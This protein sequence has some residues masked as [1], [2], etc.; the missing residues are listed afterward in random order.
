MLVTLD[1]YVTIE[2]PSDSV[3]DYCENHLTLDNPEYI[4]A[5]KRNSYKARFLDKKLYLYKIENDKFILPFGTFKDIVK[6]KVPNTIYRNEIKAL[7]SKKIKSGIKLYDYQQKAL[8]A[9][10]KAKNGIL[11]GGCGSGKTQI[12][13][14]LIA[15]LG[16]RA[17]WL[18]H[19]GDLLS[20]SYNRAKNSLECSLGKITEGK[21]NIQDVTFATVQTMVKL[22]LE[23]YKRKFDVI[24]VDECHHAVGSP[25][26]MKMFYK[27]ISSLSARYKY[28]LTATPDRA[29][30]LTK[31]M[32]ALLGNKEYE[33]SRKSIG[34][35]IVDAQ[36]KPIMWEEEPKGV[37]KGRDLLTQ[38]PIY[39][40]DYI[41]TDGTYIYSKLINTL[42]TWDER[43]DLI[44]KIVKDNPDRHI[45]ILCNLV[46]H[47]K[48]LAEDLKAELLI[49][50]KSA[51][52]R[53]EAK[54]RLRTGKSKVSVATVALLKEGVDIPILDTLIFA[55]PQKNKTIIVQSIGRIER[56]Y[57]GKLN[58]IVYDI[59]DTKIPYCMGSYSK[60]KRIIKRRIK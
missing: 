37:Y 36:Y 38:E 20:Q 22:D 6:L 30:G 45:L 35:K 15:E 2:N 39:E 42:S 48:L 29:D 23:E 43:N 1:N 57:P 9:L 26:K 47:A 28:G 5:L 21:V 16:G 4:N 32:Y 44:K 51:K 12:G 25:T 58:P 19:T 49:G 10:K 55:T 53:E 46:S 56:A 59:V 41:D 33:I 24:I 50:S 60:R 11:V 7:E 17:L 8:E 40:K 52:K 54:E 14:Q 18:T 34:E 13:L 3:I 31:A 27:I